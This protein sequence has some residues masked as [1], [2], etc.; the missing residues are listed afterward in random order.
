M[1]R[2]LLLLQ[3]H[4]S[5][6]LRLRMR[7]KA[8]VGESKR[9]LAHGE[10]SPR[11]EEGAELACNCNS[12]SG[13]EPGRSRDTLLFGLTE[14]FGIGNEL[15]GGEFEYVGPAQ[16]SESKMPPSETCWPKLFPFL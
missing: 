15:G 14:N 6:K 8:F 7:R 3:P 10:C 13:Q 4:S 16:S 1:Y 11:G 5:S 9:S 12:I 2:S